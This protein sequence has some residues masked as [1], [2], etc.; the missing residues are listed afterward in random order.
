VKKVRDHFGAQTIVSNN[1]YAHY[2]LMRLYFG[3]VQRAKTADKEKVTDAMLEQTIPTGNGEV[4]L[5]ASD[6]HVDMNTVISVAKGGSLDLL[7]DV[8]RVVA[9]SQCTKT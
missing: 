4:H 8:G 2:N 3:G 6:R 5:R 1:L 7:Q 9:P